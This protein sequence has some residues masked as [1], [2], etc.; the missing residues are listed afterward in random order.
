VAV[1]LKDHPE[2]AVQA[3]G[4]RRHFLMGAEIEGIT[5]GQRCG[6]ARVEDRED[7][8]G[9]GG[10]AE[11]VRLI[12]D[13]ETPVGERCKIGKVLG[14]ADAVVASAVDV[15]LE[16]GAEGCDNRGH[17]ELHPWDLTVSCCRSGWTHDR[18]Q[19]SP[20]KPRTL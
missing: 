1:I 9:I 4:D 12:G 20:L 16:F 17:N 13:D 18:D 10:A 14:A 19:D 15:D 5:I 3:L 6:P 2:S 8:I 11:V 7:R